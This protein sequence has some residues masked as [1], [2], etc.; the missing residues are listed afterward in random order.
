MPRNNSDSDDSDGESP[1]K[2]SLW[3][4]V[5]YTMVKPD[6][7]A[8]SS[9]AAEPAQSIEELEATIARADDKERNIGLIAAPI[10]ALVGII[11]SGSLIDHAKALHQSTSV[12]QNLT[13][14]LMGL[15]ALI[16]V[17][18]WLRKRLFLG[19]TLALFGLDLFNLHGYGYA[20]PFLMAGAW[21]LV[22]SYRLSQALKLAVGDGTR[23]RP[24]SAPPRGSL[25]RPNKRYTPPTAPAK[26]P[27][28]PKP[29]NEQKAG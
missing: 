6:D 20:I 2:L 18:A 12:Y 11:N 23:S 27:S 10:G 4:R 1:P 24:R 25:P 26:R 17:A 21:Y 19:I 13:F 22:R 7:D 28:K 8:S 9:K 3:E 29:D 16:L 14:V 5:R 15:A